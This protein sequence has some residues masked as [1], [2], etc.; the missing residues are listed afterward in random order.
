MWSLSK[1]H[2]T[3][4]VVTVLS[5]LLTLL[6]LVMGQEDKMPTR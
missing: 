1:S 2:Y 6:P 4:Q 5:I 3:Y